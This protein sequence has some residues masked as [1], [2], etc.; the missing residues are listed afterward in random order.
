MV[1]LDATMGCWKFPMPNQKLTSCFHTEW[2]LIQPYNYTPVVCLCLS[3]VMVNY[4]EMQQCYAS[5]ISIKLEDT[6]F[7]ITVYQIEFDKTEWSCFW[8]SICWILDMFQMK[9]TQMY[10]CTLCR[11]YSSRCSYIA[12]QGWSEVHWIYTDLYTNATI[13]MRRLSDVNTRKGDNCSWQ[14]L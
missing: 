13:N 14:E 6:I 1:I 10:V 8:N 3:Y 5:Y 12:V 9:Q 7:C 2:T 4:C 11:I